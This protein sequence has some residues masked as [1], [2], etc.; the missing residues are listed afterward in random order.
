M[1][2]I[3]F[4]PR[5][6]RKGLHSAFHLLPRALARSPEKRALTRQGLRKK[7]RRKGERE[8]V[9][10]PGNVR[11]VVPRYSR[12]CSLAE[13]ASAD[14][15]PKDSFNYVTIISAVDAVR[16]LNERDPGPVS[17][18]LRIARDDIRTRERGCSHVNG[19]I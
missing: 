19:Y 7:E 9:A 5:L 6:E 17:I 2:G 1:R 10:D 4:P 13:R 12:N 11:K 18:P 15:P 14:A 3:S 16:P 8:R